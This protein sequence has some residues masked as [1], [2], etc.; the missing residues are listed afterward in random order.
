MSSCSGP[1]STPANIPSIP[2]VL[3][4]WDRLV[5]SGWESRHAHSQPNKK[6][7][8]TAC[9]Y[10]SLRDFVYFVWA[11][12]SFCVWYHPGITV[13]FPSGFPDILCGQGVT[14]GCA[15]NLSSLSGRFLK[16]YLFLLIIW[17][18]MLFYELIKVSGLVVKIYR[19]YQI[20][21]VVLLQTTKIFWDN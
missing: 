11:W 20:C 3:R 21:H 5:S 1:L 17:K 13:F 14:L 12:L 10:L 7:R 2:G 18:D 19:S 6:V 16:I 8:P 9:L 15:R 4:R